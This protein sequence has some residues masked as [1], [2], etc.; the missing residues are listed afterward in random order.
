MGGLAGGR[1]RSRDSRGIP[2][3]RSGGAATRVYPALRVIWL[4]AKMCSKLVLDHHG[5]FAKEM[6]VAPND[7]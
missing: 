4:Q 3:K 6:A 2:K 1:V 5:V 7:S